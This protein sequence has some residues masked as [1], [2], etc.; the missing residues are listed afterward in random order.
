MDKQ[1]EKFEALIMG[2]FDHRQK[3]EVCHWALV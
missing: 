2:M 1:L 3:I